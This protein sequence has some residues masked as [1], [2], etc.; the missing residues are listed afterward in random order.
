MA[1]R[2]THKRFDLPKSKSRANC[3]TGKDQ[4]G[5]ATQMEILDAASKHGNHRKSQKKGQLS[6]AVGKEKKTPGGN[7]ISNRLSSLFRNHVSI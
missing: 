7:K 6:D 4:F 2:F 3:S 5:H 1:S